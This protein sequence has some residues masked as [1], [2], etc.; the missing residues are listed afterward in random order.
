MAS[1]TRNLRLLAS[2]AAPFTT[3]QP[4]FKL[5]RC[6]WLQNGSCHECLE[7]PGSASH[8]RTSQNDNGEWCVL[9]QNEYS[10]FAV[11]PCQFYLSSNNCSGNFLL[12]VWFSFS[13]FRHPYISNKYLQKHLSADQHLL[14]LLCQPNWVLLQLKDFVCHFLIFHSWFPISHQVVRSEEVNLLG[15][16]NCQ[17]SKRPF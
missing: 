13:I 9:R 17:I 4:N 5:L 8:Q 2:S 11:Y 15:I 7:T 6:G 12:A 14:L 10:A 1:K 16:R 3:S